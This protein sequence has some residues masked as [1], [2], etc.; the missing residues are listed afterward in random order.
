MEYRLEVGLGK[1][2]GDLAPTPI[3]LTTD[4]IMEFRL[5]IHTV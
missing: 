2:G 4:L 1:G 3:F 5:D